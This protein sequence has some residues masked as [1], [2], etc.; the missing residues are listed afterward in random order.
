MH[1]CDHWRP[2]SD[3]DC[4]EQNLDFVV[5]IH[6]LFSVSFFLCLAYFSLFSF[7]R[8][9]E[10]ADYEPRKRQRDNIYLLCGIVMLVCICA[11]I[12]AT[13]L[14]DKSKPEGTYVFWIESVSFWYSEYRGS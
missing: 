10:S 14:R 9:K 12:V 5:W 6:Y 8:R 7:T 11:L 1:L 13:I 2:F 3:N 4:H